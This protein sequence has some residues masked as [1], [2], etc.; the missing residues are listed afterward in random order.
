MHI[1]VVDKAN[2]YS[3]KG[4]PALS[5]TVITEYDGSIT[6]GPNRLAYISPARENH[7]YVNVPVGHKYEIVPGRILDFWPT[8]DL[9]YSYL[10]QATYII[11]PPYSGKVCG[12]SDHQHPL[13]GCSGIMP[14]AG[15]A[16]ELDCYYVKH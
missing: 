15:V 3:G 10:Y 13:T 2:G 4:C 6:S 5:N 8:N 12:I 16:Y 14:S 9:G 11:T 7:I 1:I